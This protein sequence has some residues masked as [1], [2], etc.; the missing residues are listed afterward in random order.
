MEAGV[1]VWL[2]YTL[3][4]TRCRSSLADQLIGK[5]ELVYPA[6]NNLTLRSL[7][8]ETARWTVLTQRDGR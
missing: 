3:P 1:T 7:S 8:V 6:H 4:Y 2:Y 5:A